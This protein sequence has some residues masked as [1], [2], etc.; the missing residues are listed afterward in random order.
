MSEETRPESTPPATG[1]AGASCRCGTRGR[2]C[3]RRGVKTLLLLAVLGV[4]GFF[5]WQA[6]AGDGFDHRTAALRD[7]MRAHAR[8]DK[9]AERALARFDMPAAHREAAHKTIVDAAD[10]LQPLLAAHYDARVSLIEALSA[11]RVDPVQLETLRAAAIARADRA[12]RRLVTA[13]LA[14]G[15]QLTP[16]QRRELLARWSERH[17]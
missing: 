3:G 6:W 1:E 7:P 14:L 12:S 16:Q 17:G 8:A 9:L 4:A 5:A 15:E 13:V 11:D 2:C 10:E